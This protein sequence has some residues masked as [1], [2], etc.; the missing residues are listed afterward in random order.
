MEEDRVAI[1]RDRR[2]IS[3]TVCVFL[4]REISFNMRVRRYRCKLN[5]CFSKGI[6]SRKP[7]SLR[8]AHCCEVLFERS[9]RLL[10]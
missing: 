1:I 10:I 6:F 9:I 5:K 4:Y 8:A 7:L 3:L 2:S